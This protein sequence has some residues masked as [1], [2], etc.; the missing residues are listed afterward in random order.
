MKTDTIENN[1]SLRVI[2]ETIFLYFVAKWGTLLY[3]IASLR[4]KVVVNTENIIFV[5]QGPLPGQSECWHTQ[6]FFHFQV[7]DS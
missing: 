4:S 2:C 1:I 6:D 5:S 7:D 3:R